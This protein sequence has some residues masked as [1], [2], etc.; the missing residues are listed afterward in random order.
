M[1]NRFHLKLCWGKDKDDDHDND[2]NDNDGNNDGGD[3][4]DDVVDNDNDDDDNSGNDDEG[5]DDGGAP[6]LTSPMF[7]SLS[8]C[9]PPHLHLLLCSSP[10]LAAP[11][12]F[13]PFLSKFNSLLFVNFSRVVQTLVPVAQTGDRRVEK[14]TQLS[15][16]V[17]FVPGKHQ[18]PFVQSRPFELLQHDIY[19]GF[20]WILS[21]QE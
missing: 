18:L 19:T 1:I 2:V 14:K 12:F 16:I 10:P 8:V 17:K 21:T 3:D 5:D 6:A 4:G 11:R 20:M 7:P 15:F 13:F 9:V